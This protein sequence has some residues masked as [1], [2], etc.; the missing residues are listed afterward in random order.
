M[1]ACIASSG[2]DTPGGGSSGGGSSG[3]GSSKIV[4]GW[5][6][7]SYGHR[8]TWKVRDGANTIIA[9][10]FQPVGSFGP[11]SGPSIGECTTQDI[12]ALDGYTN[13]WLSVGGD[14]V[15]VGESVSTCLSS[16]KDL[17]KKFNMNG[18]AFDMEGCLNGK[19]PE[20]RE[21]IR[22]NQSFIRD[23]NL[24]VIYVP[25]GDLW[26]DAYD[27][28]IDGPLFDY[29]APMF[30]GGADSY[31][32]NYTQT[33]VSDMINFWTCTGICGRGYAEGTTGKGVPKS[34]LLLTYQSK[35]ASSGGEG[36]NVLTM[37]SGKVKNEGYAGILGWS[38]MEDV[39][40]TSN[41]KFIVSKL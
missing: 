18:I 22:T 10:G 28:D 41:L 5:C 24:K 8:T 17:I 2:G 19:L 4:G 12:Q 37:L 1:D 31:Q 26:S 13:K 36:R 11:C 16:S 23:K 20:V 40:D 21:W 7:C 6:Q 25:Q 34:K 14:G 3:G 30:Y 29:V 39:K 38:D 33:A 32:G 35:S 27:N 15:G 9:G